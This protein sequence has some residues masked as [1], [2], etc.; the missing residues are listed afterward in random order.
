MSVVEE[1]LVKWVIENYH[2]WDDIVSDADP[3]LGP[4][5]GVMIIK[6]E[7]LPHPTDYFDNISDSSFSSIPERRGLEI[8]FRSYRIRDYYKKGYHLHEFKRFYLLHRDTYDP[9]DFK[10]GIN[11]LIHDTSPTEKL[12]IGIGAFALGTLLSGALKKK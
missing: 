7:Y 8:S 1:M 5:S 4:Q 6:S 12:I 10:S 2:D 11:H 9:K 3:Y